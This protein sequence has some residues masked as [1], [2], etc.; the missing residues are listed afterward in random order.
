[1]KYFIITLIFVTTLFAGCNSSTQ[2]KI[3]AEKLPGQSVFESNCTACHGTDGKLCV[4]GAKDLTLSVIPKED[5]VTI[6]KN[7]KNTMTPF[8]T[9]LTE[10]EIAAVADY[11][12]TFK[13]K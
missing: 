1:M 8:G 7:G 12:Q 11:V 10:E 5:A 6:I 9:I 2:P 3:S 4:L 13:A